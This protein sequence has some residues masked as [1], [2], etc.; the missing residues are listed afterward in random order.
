QAFVG[1][2]QSLLIA[3]YSSDKRANGVAGVPWLSKIPLLGALVRYHS[4]SQNHME[5]V[6]LLSPRIFD[7]G[8]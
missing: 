1:Q 7:P 8:T 6:F 2:G 5:R 4:D 3:G